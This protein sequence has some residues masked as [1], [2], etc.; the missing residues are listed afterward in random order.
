[1]EEVKEYVVYIHNDTN[2]TTFREWLDSPQS[3][4]SNFNR[5]KSVTRVDE[6]TKKKV[7]HPSYHLLLSYSSDGKTNLE[8]IKER[9][10]D[11]PLIDSSGKKI[12][13]EAI[14]LA[15][16]KDWEMPFLI[17][18]EIRIPNTYVNRELLS[19]TGVQQAYDYNYQAF[20]ATRLIELLRDPLFRK[21]NSNDGVFDLKPEVT[22]WVY[23]RVLN[24][25][26]NLSP[27]ITNLSSDSGF[28]GDS[29]SI[30]LQP[31][32]DIFYTG[33]REQNLGSYG[34][35]ISDVNIDKKS[36]IV[37]YF[38]RVLSN[39]DLVFLRHD[40]VQMDPSD[41]GLLFPDKD[42]IPRN[43]WD[44][45]GMIDTISNSVSVSGGYNS[46]IEVKGRDLLK[47]LQDDSSFFAPLTYTFDTSKPIFDILTKDKS[48]KRNFSTGNYE[49][50]FS[51]QLKTIP[52]V[53]SFVC[54][55]LSNLGLVPDNIFSGYPKEMLSRVYEIPDDV[56]GNYKT[57]ECNGVWKIIKL[58]ID[59]NLKSRILADF[60]ITQ[61]SAPLLDS[62]R[63][64]CQ[65]P[66]VEFF[67]DTYNNTYHLVAR[68]PPFNKKAITSILKSTLTDMEY[69]YQFSDEEGVS[70]NL[71]KKN[72]ILKETTSRTS[73][74]SPVDVKRTRLQSY[75]R[76]S[77]S[78][79]IDILP[80][81]V[82][83]ESLTFNTENIYT[84]F[85]LGYEG[86]STL[87][88]K[89]ELA[90]AY[91]PQIFLKPYM[92]I[93]G[94]NRLEIN[95]TY[96]NYNSFFGPKGEGEYSTFRTAAIN[97]FMYM[98]EIYAPMP[99]VRRGTITI[100]LD[101]R[102]KKG[103][104]IRYQRTGEIF[105]VLGVSHETSISNNSVEG[106]TTLQLTRGM[107]E[108]YIEGNREVTVTFNDGTTKTITPSYFNI[109]DK[110]LLQQM[111]SIFVSGKIPETEE[112]ERFRQNISK[113]WAVNT[114]IF[115]FFLQ[116]KQ[117]DD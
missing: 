80:E 92:D 75:T 13:E 87:G 70:G 101:R 53:F 88:G 90:R 107:V 9:Y 47:L 39:N 29:F 94:N 61:T 30:S 33:N 24:R 76:D 52:S 35:Y 16:K 95:S 41:P 36:G 12:R 7:Y 22:V 72:D 81:D 46:M 84:W 117:F 37:P 65:D 97:D 82:L 102:I 69:K 54:N 17:G 105:Y 50:I 34:D 60:G 78:L 19:F 27:F 62:F 71:S 104:F 42:L 77:N 6:N 91:I 79:V 67:G 93:W 49:I 25:I 83:R 45:I 21:L 5:D 55:Q 11:L 115:N 51:K 14:T 113:T 59:E 3:L 64:C 4:G 48:L 100:N 44:L 89:H 40:R 20:Y 110:E 18:T 108:K 23:S 96:Y 10:Q 86:V 56:D 111:V 1:M 99:F 103:T 58:S 8:R 26:I 32:S 57:K 68:V 109:V 31:S 66:F 28:D 2:S 73:R 112:G 98:V 85:A 38:M 43:S 116:R 15:D 114:D 74:I 106:I 63:N